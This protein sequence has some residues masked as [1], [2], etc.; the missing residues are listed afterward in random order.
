M[1]DDAKGPPAVDFLFGVVVHGLRF[2]S[3]ETAPKKIPGCRSR[4]QGFDLEANQIFT[5]I[6]NSADPFVNHRPTATDITIVKVVK[7][8]GPAW[9]PFKYVRRLESSFLTT[10]CKL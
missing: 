6:I 8:L 10:C 9:L 3:S 1:A 2:A 7:K 5:G 4:S